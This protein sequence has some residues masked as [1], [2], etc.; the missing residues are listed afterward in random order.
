MVVHE[1]FFQ[2]VHELIPQIIDVLYI[3]KTVVV[4]FNRHNPVV[5]FLLFFL[6]LLALDDPDDPALQQA[7][8]KRW[9][10]HQ[11]ENVH[12]IAIFRARS[13]HETEVVRKRPAGRKHSL[14]QK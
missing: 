14:Q 12:R 11:H 1:K 7:A 13:G 5:A 2:L 8:H 3:R 10:I 4:H 9:F 6:P